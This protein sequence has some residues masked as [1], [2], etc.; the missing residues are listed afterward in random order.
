MSDDGYLWESRVQIC[1]YNFLTY[2]I[3]AVKSIIIQ[4]T[5][6]STDSSQTEDNSQKLRI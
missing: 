5:N 3:Q 6:K 2:D 4:M 1:I